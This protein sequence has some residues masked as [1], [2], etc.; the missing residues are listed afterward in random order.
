LA[1]D[2]YHD[3]LSPDFRGRTAPQAE[4]IFRDLGLLSAFWR[5]AE[6]G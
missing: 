2:W 1:R 5:L 6:Q 4:A 3:R